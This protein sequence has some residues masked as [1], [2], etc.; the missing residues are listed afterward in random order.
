M[1]NQTKVVL[2]AIAAVF[3]MSLMVRFVVLSQ[4]GLPGTWIFYLGLPF[5][6][7]V[8]VLLLLLRLGVLNFGESSSATAQH[9][10]NTTTA[11]G[12]LPPSAPKW[13][14]LQELEAL[15]SSGAISDI[16]YAEKRERLI[17]S[18]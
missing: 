6:G 3:A 11:R 14:R 8:T 13:Q 12:P 17:S 7:I 9:W 1:N 2:G 4:A 18:I 5:G 16:E 10:Q 15:R